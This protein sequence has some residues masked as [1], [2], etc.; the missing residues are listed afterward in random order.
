MN[1]ADGEIQRPGRQDWKGAPERA[2]T[3]P[4]T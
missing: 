2:S 1:S 4:D 3:E